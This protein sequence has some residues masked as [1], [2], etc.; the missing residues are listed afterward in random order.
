MRTEIDELRDK[1]KW[2]ISEFNKEAQRLYRNGR[3]VFPEDGF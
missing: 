2:A 1:A 3:P